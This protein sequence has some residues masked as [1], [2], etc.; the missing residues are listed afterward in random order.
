MLAILG[1]FLSF[2]SCF[3]FQA[4]RISKR[5]LRYENYSSPILS[6]KLPLRRIQTKTSFF[7]MHDPLT[8]LVPWLLFLRIYQRNCN[9]KRCICRAFTRKYSIS[10]VNS[11]AYHGY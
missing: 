2:L 3:Y 9:N 11:V 6:L 4:Q 8:R 10:R 1:Y 7:L 5:I